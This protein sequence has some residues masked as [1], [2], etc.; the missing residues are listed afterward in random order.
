MHVRAWATGILLL[1]CIS[2][3]PRPAFAQ[4]NAPYGIVSSPQYL[5]SSSPGLGR[6][7][8]LGV[9][10]VRIGVDWA[11]VQSSPGAGFYFG[12]VDPWINN[13]HNSGIQVLV[14]LGGPP[15]WA[16]P[17][18]SYCVPYSMTDW[19][20]YVQAVVGHYGTSVTYQVWNEPNDNYFLRVNGWDTGHYAVDYSR[21]QPILENAIAARNNSVPSATFVVPDMPDAALGDWFNHFW[22]A[23]ATWLAPQDKLSIHVYSNGNIPWDINYLISVSGRE[24]WLT[25]TGPTTPTSDSAQSNF[26]NYLVDTFQNFGDSRWGRFFYYRLWDNANNGEAIL[27]SDWSPRPGYYTYQSRI[28]GGGC[29]A[30]CGGGPPV[31]LAPGQSLSPNQSVTSPNGQYTLVYQ[32]DGNLVEYATGGGPLW[33]TGTDGT[34]PGTA[35]MQ[36]DGNFVIYDCNGTPVWNT[37]T[38]NNPGAYLS[39]RDDGFLVICDTSGNVIWS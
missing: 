31:T 34:C 21:F 26:I 9:G 10:S 38:W 27:Y 37:G 20:N 29:G 14:D 16:A 12:Q 18:E 25:E 17:C 8:T 33:A 32:S 35:I 30:S 11:M 3:A 39:L 1:V 13:A 22:W 5:D 23:D 15:A 4:P 7:Q 19:Y 24:V 6:L 28:P 2:F 36:S